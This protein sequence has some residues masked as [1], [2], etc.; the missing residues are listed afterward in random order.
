MR[1]T[2]NM[3]IPAGSEHPL[4]AHMFMNYVYDPRIATNITE[5][6]WYEPPVA[7]VREMILADAAGPNAKNLSCAPFCR[8]LANDGFVFPDQGT[9]A[10]TI[11]YKQLDEEEEQ[12][13]NDLFQ[14]VVQG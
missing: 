7:D 10:Q 12:A 11:P 5:W 9:L 4:D 6:V 3:C 1:W 14:Q 2:D 13:W 8:D